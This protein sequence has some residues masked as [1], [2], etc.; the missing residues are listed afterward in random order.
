MSDAQEPLSADLVRDLISIP[1][2]SRDPN[3]DIITF[4]ADLLKSHGVESDII[5][6]EDR[7][8]ANLWATIGP[9]DKPGVVL[10]GHTDV[11][12]VDG[13]DWTSDPF[14][15][16]E[17]DGRFYGRG[18]CDMKG[19]I[20]VALAHLPQILKR[21]LEVPLHFAF[22]YDEELGCRGVGSLIEHITR[23]P[24]R[25]ALCIVGEPTL[26]KVI[27]GH[28]GG[29]CYE[30][31]VKGTTA[32]SS[33]A[34]RAVNAIAYAAELIAFLNE[35]T[36][37]WRTEGPFDEAY[38]ITHSTLSVTQIEAGTAFNIIPDL[39][40]F[41][42][43]YR[44]LD[45]VD[46][47]EVAQRIL[48]RASQLE[49][50]MHEISDKAG[51]EFDKTIDFKSLGMDA[52]HDAVTFVKSLVGSNADGKVAFGTEGGCFHKDAGIPTVVCGPGSIEQAHKADEFVD[53]SQLVQCEAMVARL[54][55][56][57][58]RGALGWH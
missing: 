56:R 8:K 53:K 3:R 6:N 48:K 35:I 33:L 41:V 27:L 16:R 38:D 11:V 10:S 30:V 25:P 47:E 2:V 12:P 52:A 40:S 49:K 14:D 34:P 46:P 43:E 55:D 32:H 50:R 45:A 39:C 18:T 15:V 57:L 4:I 22:S 44:H 28:K 24:V 19:F 37:E 5:W 29:R 58:E 20:A 17:A 7:T 42:F 13:Q 31:K 21:N 9:A 51:F 1:T 23:Q 36:E 54:L 26:M